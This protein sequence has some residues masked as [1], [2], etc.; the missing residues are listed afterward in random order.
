MTRGSPEGR[1]PFRLVV[2]ISYLAYSAQRKVV[3]EVVRRAL[4]GAGAAVM[5]LLDHF[6]DSVDNLSDS[7]DE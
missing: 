7:E 3:P 4:A 2:I 6:R 1:Q 5:S